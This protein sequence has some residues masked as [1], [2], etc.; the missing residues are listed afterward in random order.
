MGSFGSSARDG[1]SILG[2]AVHLPGLLWGKS[3]QLPIPRTACL[4]SEGHST[5]L[6]AVLK[7]RQHIK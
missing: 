4:F 2:L 3:D 1:E 7:Y 6:G 5:N